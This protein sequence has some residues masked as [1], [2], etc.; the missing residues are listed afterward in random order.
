MRPSGVTPVASTIMSPAPEQANWPRCMRCQSVMRPCSAEYWHIG[1]TTMRLGSVMPPSRIGV[2]SLGSGN[3]D[4][5]L[6]EDFSQGP[7]ECRRAG[8]VAVQAQR[9]GGDRNVLAGQAGH[10][11]L[12]DHRQRLLHR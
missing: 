4:S 8:L 9:I 2:N 3:G 5:L 12:L 6:I 10:I 7:R 1:D 11:A